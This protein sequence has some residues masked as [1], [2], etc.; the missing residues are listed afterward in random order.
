MEATEKQFLKDA[1]KVQWERFREFDDHEGAANDEDGFFS[2]E[3]KRKFSH[4][5]SL[6]SALNESEMQNNFDLS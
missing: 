2:Y 1:H 3:K 5:E 6:L 4:K